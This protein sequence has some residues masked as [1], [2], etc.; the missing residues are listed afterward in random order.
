VTGVWLPLFIPPPKEEPL[1]DIAE[2]F[3]GFLSREEDGAGSWL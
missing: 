2:P 1:D 3:L